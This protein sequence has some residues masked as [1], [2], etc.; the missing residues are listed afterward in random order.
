MF[1]RIN[2]AT[3]NIPTSFDATAGSL[4]LTATSAGACG[5]INTTSEWLVATISSA[6]TAVPSSDTSV[7]TKQYLFP[8]S[9]GTAGSVAAQVMDYF[10]INN[11]DK[12][13]IRTLDAPATSGYVGIVIW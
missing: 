5:L 7:N 11:G 3:N 12:V 1:A 13:Y 2:A 9:A 4:I 10:S 6:P 8:P